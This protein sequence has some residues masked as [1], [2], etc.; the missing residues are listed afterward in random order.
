RP[1]AAT[2][3]AAAGGGG[4]A[5]SAGSAGSAAGAGGAGGAIGSAGGAAGAGRATGSAR[6]ARGG[7]RRSL[8]L[9]G[10]PT[11]Q[12]LREWV[13]QRASPGGGGFGFLRT[14]QRR[15]QSQQETFSPQVLSELFPQRCVTGSVEAAALGASEFA[16]ALGA[17]ESAAALGAKESAAALGARASPATGPSSAE[18]LHTFTLDSGASRCFFRD[19]TTF[20]PLAAPVPV[21]LAD[22][23]GGPVVARASTVLPFP[24][25]PSGSLSGLHLPTFLMN[26]RVAICT[27]SRTGRHLAMFTRRPGSS[28][29]TLTTTSAQVAEAG[30]VTH[31]YRVSAVCTPVSFSLA[32]PGPCLPSRARLPHR[33]LPASRGG[34]APLLTPPSLLRPLLLC[35]LSTWTRDFP[36]LRLHSDR[37]GEFSSD[38]LAEFCRDEG[39]VKSFTL[40]ASPQ[41]NE[42]AERRIGLIMELNLW[43]RVS[44]LETSPTLRWM[45]KVGD[46][47]VFRVWGALSLVRDAKASKLSSRTLRCV[48]L[49]FP[50]D[51]LPWQFYHPRSRSC[52]LRCVSGRPNPLG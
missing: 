34:S 42:I 46:A 12:Q 16:A 47:S 31:P 20:T 13:L 19:C 28:L 38:L 48:F 25:V 40:P 49:G 45:G 26:L 33:A 1:A 14:A 9:S 30:Q 32:F 36:V 22:P 35:R 50:T 21:S 4:A 24:P 37:G 39:I 7:Q 27:C 3:A 41:Q 29:Y 52:F 6:V 8:P 23:T 43:P 17:S 15:Q 18:A 5:G 51:A 11:P 44:E 10:D 2:R